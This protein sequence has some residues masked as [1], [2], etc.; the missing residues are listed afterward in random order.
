MSP[1]RLTVAFSAL[2]WAVVVGA[3]LVLSACVFHFPLWLTTLAVAVTAIGAG[4]GAVI[5]VR[6]VYM[7]EKA[8]EG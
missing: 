6:R 3:V 2:Y 7:R 8:K 5:G 4:T 1:V